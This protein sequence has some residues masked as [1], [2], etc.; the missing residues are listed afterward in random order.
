MANFQE[1]ARTLIQGLANQKR[2]L[3]DLS[4]ELEAVKKELGDFEG[5][6]SKEVKVI[7]DRID[8]INVQIDKTIKEAIAQLP[9]QITPDEI[10]ELI[11][12][13]LISLDAKE[14]E[15]KTFITDY[16]VKA[17]AVVQSKV[18]DG[19]DG[20]DGKDGKDA[21]PKQI[22][23]SVE[24][25]INENI[26]S[27]KGADGKDGKSIQGQS[28]K[29]G[30]D[31]VGIANIERSK[32]DLLITL[33]DG[34]EK[35]FKLPRISVGG[36]GISLDQAQIFEYSNYWVRKTTVVPEYRQYQVHEELILDAE[37]RLEGDL[38]MEA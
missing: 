4:I 32:D 17:I 9:K 38:I 19:I 31:G 16:L 20:V 3:D 21:T 23:D 14:D 35:R 27:L 26:D 28:G 5:E 13:Q 22:A 25:W 2:T 15:F 24:A 18:K 10:N 6:Y 12:S 7:N 34:S 37:L 33:T 1:I 30:S 11:S 36:G 29:D 8:A